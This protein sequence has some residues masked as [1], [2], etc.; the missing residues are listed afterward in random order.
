[1]ETAPAIWHPAPYEHTVCCMQQE[2]IN[3]K[4]HRKFKRWKNPTT[5]QDKQKISVKRRKKED[6]KF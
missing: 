2:I 5:K 6:S 1:M 4:E 3:Q